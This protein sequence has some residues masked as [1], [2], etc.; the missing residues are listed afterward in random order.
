MKTLILAAAIGLL[1]TTFG[2]APGTAATAQG[3]S[4]GPAISAAAKTET[5]QIY[6]PRCVRLMR[7]CNRGNIRACQLYRAEC[8]LFRPII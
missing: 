5:A 7:R 3:V 6:R 1:L 8:R 2:H 4:P